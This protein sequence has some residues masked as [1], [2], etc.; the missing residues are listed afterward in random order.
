MVV[1]NRKDGRRLITTLDL[2]I[3]SSDGCSQVD[4]VTQQHTYRYIKLI[5]L[6]RCRYSNRKLDA[7]S[8]DKAY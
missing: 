7:E 6:N 5:P 8:I 1:V 2:L 4:L 3:Q